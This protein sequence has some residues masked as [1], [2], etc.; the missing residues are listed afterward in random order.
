MNLTK[1]TIYDWFMLVE[2]FSERIFENS[3]VIFF[4][5]FGEVSK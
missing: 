2:V 3:N 5:L 4:F 1:M